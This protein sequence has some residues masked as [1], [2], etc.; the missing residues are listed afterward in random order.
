[1]ADQFVW[2]HGNDY[3]V[4]DGSRKGVDRR[5]RSE[6][7]GCIASGIFA[8]N[9]LERRH[10][11]ERRQ[12]QD[13]R[14]GDKTSSADRLTDLTRSIPFGIFLLTI[15]MITL[16][17]GITIFPSINLALGLLL[18]TGGVFFIFMLSRK[19]SP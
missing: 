9:V 19:R 8:V 15:S 16:L 13:R 5:V 14:T 4:L 11:G 10:N 2:W 7:R 1:M 12:I 18:V 17:S 6:R 3:T